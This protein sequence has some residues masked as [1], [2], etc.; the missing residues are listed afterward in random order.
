MEL[1][2]IDP[3]IQDWKIS[4][5]FK[6]S[7]EFHFARYSVSIWKLYIF[8][9]AQNILIYIS[10]IIHLWFLHAR[11]RRSIAR[12]YGIT[13]TFSLQRH[14]HLSIWL[15]VTTVQCSRRSPS[16]EV[17]ICRHSI[18]ESS[19][20]AF[21]S[22]DMRQ[23]VLDVVTSDCSEK[24]SSKAFSW[25]MREYVKQMRYVIGASFFWNL[26]SWVNLPVSRHFLIHISCSLDT[27]RLFWMEFK[28]RLPTTDLIGKDGT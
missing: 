2:D 7:V 14:Y 11:V 21:S 24:F 23:D 13:F 10:V 28:Q 18:L 5:C 1:R 4:R 6:L 20:S 12:Y 19:F 15:Y 8:H 25:G 27:S 22:W 26:G 9:L 17:W 16:F 3:N